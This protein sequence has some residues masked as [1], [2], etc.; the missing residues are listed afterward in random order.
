M[1]TPTTSYG[2]L[3]E[4]PEFVQPTARRNEV[5]ARVREGLHDI[6]I[7]RAGLDWGIKVPGDEQHTVYVWIDALFNYVS[8]V[9]TPERRHSGR[10]TS[11]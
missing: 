2:L 6:P 1:P 4:R 8:A 5:V 10:P 3:D 7:S 11:T 9:D